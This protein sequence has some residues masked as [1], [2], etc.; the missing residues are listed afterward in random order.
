MRTSTFLVLALASLAG[1][2]AEPAAERAAE[3]VVDR[4]AAPPA[5]LDLASLATATVSGVYDEAATLVDG[6]FLGEPYVEGSPMAPQLLWNREIVHFADLDGD[7]EVDALTF[8]TAATG[9]SGVLLYLG[10]LEPGAQGTTPGAVT[11]AVHLLGD[12]VQI[13][14]ARLV[15]RT[16]HVRM[17]APGPDDAACCPTQIQER[18]Y[19]FDPQGTIHES[20]DVVGT[21]SF[22]EIAGTTWSLERMH[23]GAEPV[24]AEVEVTLNFLDGGVAGK[25]G[26]N[27]Y[28]GTVQA[29]GARQLGFGPL[30]TTKMAC[31]PPLSTIEDQFLAR[32]AVVDSWSFLVGRLAL[33]Y[34]L[35]GERG[36]LI[37]IGE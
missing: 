5:P 29:S 24:P 16:L 35:D 17:V 37:L 1:C 31:P 6:E 22:D 25:S 27:N 13:R 14:S 33:S 32:L 30:A 11:R 20:I 7:D 34:E 4:A 12:R 2:S 15:D 36:A 10:W 8:Y 21:L 23:F 19:T 28:R 3:P 18:R 9:G 26:C